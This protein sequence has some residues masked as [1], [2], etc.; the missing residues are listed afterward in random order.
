MVRSGAAVDAVDDDGDTPLHEAARHGRQDVVQAL[1]AA[2]AA[3]DAAS[4]NSN[5]AL[6]F[7]ALAR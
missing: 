7:A 6:H 4:S 5:T 3:V 1:L 2:G